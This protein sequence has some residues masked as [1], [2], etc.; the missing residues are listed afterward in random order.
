MA[1]Q[2]VKQQAQKIAESCSKLQNMVT[3]DAIRNEVSKIKQYCAT[4][5]SQI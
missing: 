5:E 3:E 4:I 2:Q 1:S